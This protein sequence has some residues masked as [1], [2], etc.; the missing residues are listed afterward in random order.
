VLVYGGAGRGVLPAIDPAFKACLP[1]IRVSFVMQEIAN[2]A[3][4]ANGGVMTSMSG[5][6]RRR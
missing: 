5:A 4:V 6:G 2:A 3:A 1:N